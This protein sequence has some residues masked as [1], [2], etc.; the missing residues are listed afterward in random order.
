MTTIPRSQLSIRD[1]WQRGLAANATQR[2]IDEGAKIGTLR[3]GNSGCL[4]DVDNEPTVLGK[5]GRLT[6]L[7]SLGWDEA[8]EDQRQLMFG[9]GYD[10]E[11]EWLGTL[12]R[13]YGGTIRR[14]GEI[15]IRWTTSSGVVVTGRP[16]IVMGQELQRGAPSSEPK[17]EFTPELGLELKLV[18]SIWTAYDVHYKLVP[19]TPHLV[20]A[21]HYMW[22]LGVPYK[23]LY[24]SRV[25]WHPPRFPAVQNK[26]LSAGYD[27]K[28]KDGP[29]GAEVVKIFPF[30]REYELELRD[31][32][33]Y[34]YTQGLTA[35]VETYITI[36]GIQAYYEW[37]A[38]LG[39]QNPL[40]PRPSA[41]TAVGAAM[42][43]HPCDFCPLAE[44]CDTYEGDYS[45]WLDFAKTIL[46]PTKE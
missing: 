17:V 24:T 3:A 16:D 34:Y 44:V 22:Q 31:G 10:N 15:P 45:L 23:L 37:V 14:E 40:G 7:R 43:Y 1:L 18:S 36:E 5:C 32:R 30:F 6:H 19:K 33:L 28:T 9:A 11:D 29:R 25:D 38:Q 12:S 2:S 46:K 35:P 8:T 20:Q 27:I 4:V 42:S 21:A 26:I 41:Q 39:P 13:G